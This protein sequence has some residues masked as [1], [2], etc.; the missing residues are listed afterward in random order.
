MPTSY[1]T[2]E[3]AEAFLKERFGFG[4]RRWLAKLRTAGGGPEFHKAGHRVYYLP[5]T[6][7]QWALSRI[8]PP[9]KST[10]EYR[11]RRP[12]PGEGAKPSQDEEG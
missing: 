8:S 1:L 9:I 3:R 6:L 7:E 10:S 2:T 4:A 12:A 11:K 5:E